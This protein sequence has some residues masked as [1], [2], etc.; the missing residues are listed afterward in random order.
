MQ[1]AIFIA[2]PPGTSWPLDMQTL[3]LRLRD[4]LPDVHVSAPRQAGSSGEDYIDFQATVDGQLRTGSYFDRATLIL[5]DGPPELWA[6]T[7]VWFL[8]QLSG[9]ATAVAMVE[10][11]PEQVAPVPPTATAAEVRALLEQLADVG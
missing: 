4:Q 2:A 8:A 3:G 5:R 1:D 7:I 11:N 10:S 9:G 6:D